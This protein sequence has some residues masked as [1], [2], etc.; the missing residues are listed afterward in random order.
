MYEYLIKVLLDT[1][2]FI[3]NKDP[4]KQLAEGKEVGAGCKS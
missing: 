3:R 1:G 4:K 2:D